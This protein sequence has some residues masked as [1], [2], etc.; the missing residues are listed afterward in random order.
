M[1]KPP[2]AFIDA[3]NLVME[4]CEATR[5]EAKFEKIRCKE[6]YPVAERC[7]IEMARCI[8]ERNTK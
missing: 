5:E 3:F 7:Y 1:N 8:N 6:N 4:Y 2:Q